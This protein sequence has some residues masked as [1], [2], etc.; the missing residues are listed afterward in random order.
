MRFKQLIACFFIGYLGLLLNLGPSLHRAHFFGLH[1]HGVVD[2]TESCSCGGHSHSTSEVPGQSQ[3][4]HSEHECVFCKFFD[5]FHVTVVP[6]DHV[7]S[8]RIGQLVQPVRPAAIVAASFFP[9]A[10]G[11]PAL[12]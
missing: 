12:V 9:T 4:V 11:P 2:S 10:R 5:Q 6:Y 8:T 1:S 7:D 3:S